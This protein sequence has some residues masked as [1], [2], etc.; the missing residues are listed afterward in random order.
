[1]PILIAACPAA[2]H[3]HQMGAVDASHRK[4]YFLNLEKFRTRLIEIIPK[5]KLKKAWGAMR[6]QA[7]Q[8]Q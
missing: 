8:F 1:M 5:L 2:A 4:C 6:H 7:F 3:A